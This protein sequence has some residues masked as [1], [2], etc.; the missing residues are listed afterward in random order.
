MNYIDL[1]ATGG[2]GAKRNSTGKKGPRAYIPTIVVVI[3]IVMTVLNIGKVRTVLAKMLNPISIVS[4]VT[5]GKVTNL[6]RLTAEQIFYFWVRINVL[7][8]SR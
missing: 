2:N 8:V 5:G 3:L 1:K 7:W 6:R 4:S